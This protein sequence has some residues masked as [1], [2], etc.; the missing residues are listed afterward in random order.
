LQDASLDL[1]TRAGVLQDAKPL[2]TADQRSRVL[3]DVT[4]EAAAIVDLTG[5][6]RQ[7]V[8]ATRLAA[9]PRGA[10]P[11]GLL[12]TFLYRAPGRD[13]VVADPEGYLRRWRGRGT[14]TWAA[15]PMRIR[16]SDLLPCS[17]SSA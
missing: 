11:F 2:M 17:P 12:T 9:R 16:G 1:A 5:L 8:A 15:E 3:A 13:R 6:E 14:C 4:R 10:G 7:A